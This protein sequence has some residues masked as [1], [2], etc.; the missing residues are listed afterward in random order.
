MKKPILRSLP[1]IALMSIA[2]VAVGQ[3]SSGEV[4]SEEP[5]HL[6]L[7]EVVITSTPLTRTLGQSI[8]SSTALDEEELAERIASSIGETLRNQPGVKS[9]AF[10]QAAGRP[11]IRGLGGDRI[12]VLED[13]LGSFDV[14][15]TSPDH[16]VPIEPALAERVEI[17]RGSASL[18]YGSS[19]A[20]GVVN[21]ET[22]K[23]PTALPENGFDGATR[24]AHS[25]VDNGDEVAA[26][27][28]V[29]L[30]SNFVLHAEGSFRE[31]G[32]FEIDGLNASD[33]L[34]DLFAAQAA[35]E[36]EVF[37][38]ADTEFVDGFVPN[39]D[40]E[41]WTG[42]VGGSFVF[43]QGG[44][45]G[46][47]GASFTI[48][49]SNYG[50]PPGILTEEDLEGEEEE[51]EGEEEGIRIDLR[52]LRYDARGEINGDL[53]LFKTLKLRLGYGDY[54]H[55]ELEG[56][57]VGT[58]FINDEFE[59]RLEAVGK[60]ISAF[61]GN[62]GTA[63]GFQVRNRDVSAFG[64]E[65]FVPPSEQLQLGVFGLTEYT[66]GNLIIDGS[67]RY[68]YVENSTDEFIADE[69][70][71][72]VPV[73]T[74][75]NIFSISGGVGYQLSEN[76]FVGVNG[77]R[78][79]RAPSVEETFSFGPHLATQ[80]FEI[81]DPTLENEVARSLEATAR[82]SFGPLTLILNGFLTD[83]DNF[84]FEQLTDAD[85]DGELDVLDGLPVLSFIAEDTR[86]R[87]F[88]AQL[89]ADLG[90]V[91]SD[92]FGDIGFSL[93]AQADFVRATSSGL[94]DSDQPRIP[95]FSFLVG[96]GASSERANLRL[97]VE[98]HADQNDV[99]AF[100]LPTDSFT[101]VN[102]F[103][104]YRPFKD[105]PNIAF[106]F[107]AKN[108]NDDVGRLSTS[109]LRDTAPLL[110]RDFRFGVRYNF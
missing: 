8:T 49:D 99:A 23:I 94:T 63:I 6:D 100:E 38:L 75:F 7:D 59:L 109:F 25:T 77:A 1:L 60:D 88:E 48:V 106:D 18:L 4:N 30:G 27:A 11:V 24:Y 73:D 14:S 54:E 71:T 12:R 67:A 33:Q 74:D 56:P 39:S 41:T 13:S 53:G 92:Y 5:S 36:G 15:Q 82:G 3:T 2:P 43:D 65:A 78:T 47:F 10:G 55:F 84:I 44:Y 107:R 58:E 80:S 28:N 64:A 79:E 103:F 19:A 20:G 85:G 93:R 21:V 66:N 22:G 98:Y 61:G 90:T 87:G 40:L 95:P 68:E 42:S 101:F 70:A 83:Y 16:A 45:D 62:V 96:A 52:Q 89:D 32:N 37:D 86:F 97:E 105:N 51:E 29:Q 17:V 76:L 69:D 72:P 108:L 81:G 57:E 91:P 31:A 104:T 26:G 102:L 35:A 50:L 110:G 9:T 46:F 34:L